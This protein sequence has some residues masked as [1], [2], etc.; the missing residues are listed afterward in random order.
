MELGIEHKRLAFVN[1]INIAT[2]NTSV[3]A[4][5]MKITPPRKSLQIPIPS[6]FEAQL[7]DLGLLSGRQQ[8]QLYELK[9]FIERYNSSIHDDQVG[10]V[11]EL[12]NQIELMARQLELTT[13]HRARKILALPEM[14][15]EAQR[16]DEDNKIYGT[17]P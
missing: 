12:L 6:F 3:M 9:Y 1:A 13:K 15:Q 17:T 8:R 5:T 7:E 4:R 10:I 16:L 14:R 2:N 11:N